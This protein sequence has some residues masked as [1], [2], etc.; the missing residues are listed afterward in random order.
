VR[1]RER[2]SEQPQTVARSRASLGFD[3]TYVLYPRLHGLGQGLTG[4]KMLGEKGGEGTERER[5]GESED[6]VGIKDVGLVGA[7][8]TERETG[9]VGTKCEPRNM[10]EIQLGDPP[11]AGVLSHRRSTATVGASIP[12]DPG[13]P[14]L[15]N[16]MGVTYK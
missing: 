7:E 11:G 14:G 13:C 2:Q 1:E 10:G 12:S 15:Q 8:V 3:C 6:G 4:R 16:E 9:C 5:E